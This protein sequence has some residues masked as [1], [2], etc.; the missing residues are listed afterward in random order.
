MNLNALAMTIGPIIFTWPQ[1]DDNR[2]TDLLLALL[3]ID[4][5]INYALK[6]KLMYA[7]EF[8]HIL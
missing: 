6:F 4:H 1:I 7:P 5:V 3:N 8:I 2:K